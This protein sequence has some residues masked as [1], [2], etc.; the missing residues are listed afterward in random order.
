FFNKERLQKYKKLKVLG[1]NTTGHPHIDM[2]FC[3]KKKIK[4]VTLKNK[5][6]F[7]KKITATPELTLGL[8]IMIT[9]NI[10]PASK[11]VLA[12]NWSRWEFGGLKML[13]SM[14]LGIVGLGRIGN[15]LAKY[16]SALNMKISYYDPMVTNKKYKKILKLN[17]LA[18]NVDILSVHV[19]HEKNTEN[20]INS[21]IIS[22]M[23]KNS[24]LIN[25]SRGEI[26][27]WKAVLKYLK[28]N[29]LRGVAMDVFDGEFKTGFK[30]NIQNHPFL[31]YAKKNDNV[32]LTPHIGGSTIESW[33]MT[34]IETIKN[35][36]NHL[37]IKKEE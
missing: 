24:F 32:I 26:I 4:V 15:Q 28:N 35:V 31:N 17:E 23:K 19:P 29:K 9:R 27:D 12:G 7:L 18:K 37:N 5:K 3:K 8:I 20:L 13:S 33:Q 16:A 10:L 21:K 30:K 36:E 14:K 6:K 25:T 2:A 34:E 11:S 22:S 1:S